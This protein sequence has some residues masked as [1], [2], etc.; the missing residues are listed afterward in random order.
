[1]KYL[2]GSARSSSWTNSPGLRLSVARLAS[3][4]E[5][6]LVG[7]AYTSLTARPYLIG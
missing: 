4:F 7:N 1:M 2:R 3:H 6:R 5:E